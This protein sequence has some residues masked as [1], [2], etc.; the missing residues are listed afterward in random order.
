MGEQ[1]KI[2]GLVFPI[3]IESAGIFNIYEKF[4]F[5]DPDGSLT[6]SSKQQSKFSKWVRSD[7]LFAYD[8]RTI[9]P[10]YI[11][12]SINGYEVMQNAVGDCSVV[13]SLAVAAHY[14]F[15]FCYKK[16][17]ISSNIYPQDENGNPIYSPTGKYI[18]KLFL[19][20]L[21]R[22]I[23]LDDFFPVTHS[24]TPLCATSKKGKLWVSLLEKAYLKVKGGY[25]FKGS[26]SSTDLYAFTS[27]MPEKVDLKTADRK[28]LWEKIYGGVNNNDCLIT[29]ST[30]QVE[31][32]EKI[33]L[34]GNHAYAVLEVI[35]EGGVHIMLV[36][37]PWGNFRWNGK[38]STS[39]T[40]NWNEPLKKKLH[41]YDLAEYDNGIFWIDFDSVIENFDNLDIN[42]N[43]SLLVYRRSVW[44]MWNAANLGNDEYNLLRNP[45]YAIEFNLKSEEK[46]PEILLWAIL[47]KIPLPEEES[48]S[49]E[50]YVGL[51]AFENDKFAKIVYDERS[52][53]DLVLTNGQHYL[54]K[55]TIPKEILYLKRF[56]CLVV[57]HHKR[58]LTLPFQIQLLSSCD[59]TVNK[60]S[61]G[62]GIK[63]SIPISLTFDNS[64]G[65]PG[66]PLFYKNPQYAIRAVSHAPTVKQALFRVSLEGP[67]DSSVCIFLTHPGHTS[68]VLNFAKEIQ[69][70]HSSEATT[71]RSQFAWIETPLFTNDS[72]TVILS[73]YEPDMIGDYIVNF[74]SDIPLTL[75][76]ILPEGY[77]LKITEIQGAW[78]GSSCGG[79]KGGSY[80]NHNPIYAFKITSVADFQA[81]IRVLQEEISPGNV[82]N[83]P[84]LFNY[85]V[86]MSVYRLVYKFPPTPGSLVIGPALS[87]SLVTYGGTYTNNSPVLVTEKKMLQPGTYIIIPSTYEPMQQGQFLII[88]FHSAVSGFECVK[89][90]Q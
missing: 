73:N 27:W 56:L 84:S 25:N 60:I 67:Q 9:K 79:P 7:K 17:L 18:V 87:E 26:N 52:V 53:N 76:E 29:I 36:K 16:S 44:D 78:S 50:D 58:K 70:L 80:Y 41:F 43:P 66:C 63:K 33:G 88:L 64:G 28:T 40:L 86:S 20:G 65:R 47:T 81:R 68:R 22:M 90:Q 5:V 59:F 14:E 74:E 46:S 55:T 32:E 12:H 19:N 37:N 31:D 85:G 4:K 39:D 75:E 2:G 54:F 21:W 11:A 35:Q 15:K 77:G 13:S 34:K 61:E 72:Y 48:L 23:T 8:S 83:D 6:L 49:S 62:L 30:G 42:W 51:S 71:Y 57:R 24:G 3:W 45:Q 38:Y 10:Q 89:Y 82:V 1:C 69:V